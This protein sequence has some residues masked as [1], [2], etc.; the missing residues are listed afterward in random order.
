MYSLKC[1]SYQD[2]I[3]KKHFYKELWRYRNWLYRTNQHRTGTDN[4]RYSKGQRIRVF[5]LYWGDQ[6]L[7]IQDRWIVSA[8]HVW[9]STWLE[10]W[11]PISGR[12]QG[13]PWP[14][15][16][17]LNK[18]LDSRFLCRYKHILDIY[19]Y[20]YLYNKRESKHL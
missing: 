18:C 1:F 14:T 8:G 6:W 3:S 7:Y 10:C 19:K 16:G 20:I 12:I 17:S 2:S 11:V 15:N 4:Y 13:M 9:P 5:W